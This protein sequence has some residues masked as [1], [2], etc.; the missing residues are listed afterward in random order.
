MYS[1][2]YSSTYS[3]TPADNGI[4]GLVGLL[5]LVLSYV[6]TSY[7][8]SRIFK[9]AGLEQWKA[10]V[11]LYNV[12]L[13]YKL[14]DQPGWWTILLFVPVVNIVATVLLYIAYYKI[15]LKLGKP[16]VFV[17]WAIFLPIVWYVWL[18]FDNSTWKETG[19]APA[20]AT[21]TPTTA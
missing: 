4:G 2:D 19:A 15:G 12:W 13:T 20:S 6:I 17:L 14:G 10:W 11:P 3:S 7:L 18:A 21:D 9:K 8:L 5:F 16:G 1:S